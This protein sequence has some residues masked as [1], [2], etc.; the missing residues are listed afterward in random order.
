MSDNDP[1]AQFIMDVTGSKVP[2]TQYSGGP[3]ES[4]CGGWALIP[5]PGG[6]SHHWRQL[7]LEIAFVGKRGRIQP[8]KS[9]CGALRYTDDGIHALDEGNLPRCKKCARKALGVHS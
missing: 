6:M 2:P 8:W 7:D 1:R 4:F 5:F 3:I 9:L